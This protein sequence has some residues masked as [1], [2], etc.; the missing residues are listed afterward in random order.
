MTKILERDS[1]Y[2][3]IH[4][5]HCMCRR[6]Q[7]QK[8]FRYLHVCIMCIFKTK[9]NGHYPKEL[10]LN[11]PLKHYIAIFCSPKNERLLCLVSY[12]CPLGKSASSSHPFND[13][14]IDWNICV[15]NPLRDL[16]RERSSHGAYEYWFFL[17]PLE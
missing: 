3:I 5:K 15:L 11:I 7:N 4:A 10:A 2:D 16:F 1:K 17:L 12:P 13:G 9:N 8:V 14:V 6:Q